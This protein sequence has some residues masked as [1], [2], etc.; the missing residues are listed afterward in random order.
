MAFN[1]ITSK[2]TKLILKRLNRIPPNLE[3]RRTDLAKGIPNPLVGSVFS[4]LLRRNL[5]TRVGEIRGHYQKV[6]GKDQA[7]LGHQK[8]R[9]GVIAMRKPKASGNG[10][11][12]KLIIPENPDIEIED[13]RMHDAVVTTYPYSKS[14]DIIIAGGRIFLGKELLPKE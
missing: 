14:T 12:A 2:N 1:K 13:H 6:T 7:I 4:L 9:Y 5:V 11:T 10:I 8:K 3:F